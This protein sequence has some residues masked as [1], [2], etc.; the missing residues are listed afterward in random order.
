MPAPVTLVVA[1][2][3]S[4]PARRTMPGRARGIKPGRAEEKSRS[5][6]NAFTLGR[7][8]WPDN[9]RWAKAKLT[10]PPNLPLCPAR[11]A[12]DQPRGD[13]HE[14]VLASD[15]RG[16]FRGIV[17]S[18]RVQGGCARAVRAAKPDHLHPRPSSARRRE[19]AAAA[20]DRRPLLRAAGGPAG[21]PAGERSAGP[22][23]RTAELG[24]RGVPSSRAR[25]WGQASL[26]GSTAANTTCRSLA[27]RC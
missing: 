4:P 15:G 17:A 11:L 7:L 23:Y 20:G 8:A 3:P 12:A 14:T 10:N 1:F 22:L 16:G 6:V 2:A 19:I 25:P 26:V 27:G 24:V 21:D 13:R 5:S 9:H 18:P